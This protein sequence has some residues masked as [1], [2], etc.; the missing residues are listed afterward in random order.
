[1][2][3]GRVFFNRHKS[4]AQHPSPPLRSRAVRPALVNHVRSVED[5]R[6]GVGRSGAAVNQQQRIRA[7]TVRNGLR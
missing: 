7:E 3:A 6:L 5:V 4:A 2:V 1:M